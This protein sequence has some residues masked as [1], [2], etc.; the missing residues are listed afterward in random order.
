MVAGNQ[1]VIAMDLDNV[2]A[3]SDRVIR[4]II[5]RISGVHLTQDDIRFYDYHKVL[6]SRGIEISEAL[7]IEHEAL[8]TF[9]TRAS[10]DVNPVHGAQQGM[11]QLESSGW[12][13]VIVTSRPASSANA[14]KDWLREKEIPY[15]SIL[16]TEDKAQKGSRW[17]I[18]VEDAPHHALAASEA[19]VYVVLVDYPWNRGICRSENIHRVGGWS[20]IVDAIGQMGRR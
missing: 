1:A 6:V 2:I 10:M 3:D 7:R 19:G 18:L 11:S 8:E 5:H 9:H 17:K 12:L 4:G 16:F 13:P 20:E 15:H 14:T